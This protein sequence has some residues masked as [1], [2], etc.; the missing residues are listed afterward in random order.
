MTP[1]A[2]KVAGV[3]GWPISHS[4]SPRLHGYWIEKYG[5]NA[6]YRA[7]PVKAEDLDARL[8]QLASECEAEGAVFRGT[9][10]TIPLKEQALS[11]VDELD[12]SARRIGA[13]NTVV[14]GKD[15]RLIGRNTDAIG[16]T[17]SLG[18]H[19]ET[20]GLAGGTALVL[21]AGGAARAV[22][23]ALVDLGLGKI[24]I[25]NRSEA[26]A[27]SLAA[28]IGDGAQSLAW[29][30]RADVL[31]AVDILVN[32]TSLGMSGQPPLDISLDRL[33]KSAVVS[34]IVYVPLETDLLKMARLQGNVAVDGL[35][36]LLHQAKAGFAAWFGVTPGVD[37]ALRHHVLQG[38][39]QK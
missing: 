4:L 39:T 37:A 2:K 26:R 7:W 1:G 9:N 22:A 30:A 8:R 5:L 38:L 16:F 25:C 6:D 23:T 27:Q 32:C 24:L 10:L 36:M 20:T 34:D 12:A 3:M 13:V 19:M 18:E 14:V 21:G 33:K 15:G 11:I 17:D 31:D 28:D 29:E 35:G